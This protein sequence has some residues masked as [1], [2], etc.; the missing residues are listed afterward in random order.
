MRRATLQALPSGIIVAFSACWVWKTTQSATVTSWPTGFIT[1][2]LVAANTATPNDARVARPARPTLASAVSTTRQPDSSWSAVV[3]VISNLDRIQH[4]HGSS[5]R[6]GVINETLQRLTTVSPSARRIAATV[7]NEEIFAVHTPPGVHL[8]RFADALLAITDKPL[9]V[10]ALVIA[11]HV[12][13]SRCSAATPEGFH[14]A[15]AAAIKR[16]LHAIEVGATSCMVFGA[17]TWHVGPTIGTDGCKRG[18]PAGVLA[19]PA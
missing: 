17:E 2:M 11:P 19:A 14:V 13:A 18:A 1:V 10:N 12:V 8:D 9:H 3:L 16:C 6:F 15:M 5:V 7:P 4:Q